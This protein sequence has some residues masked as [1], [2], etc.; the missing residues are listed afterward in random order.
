M[1]SFKISTLYLKIPLV[2][3]FFFFFLSALDK[4]VM[5]KVLEEV[6]NGELQLQFRKI[7]LQYPNFSLF[8]MRN[9]KIIHTTYEIIYERIAELAVRQ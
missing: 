1:N 6:W 9:T 7:K 4:L 5:E 3:F 8:V 2:V